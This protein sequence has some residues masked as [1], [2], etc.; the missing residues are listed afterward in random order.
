ME[1]T[2]AERTR[3]DR[4]H[5]TPSH[6]LTKTHTQ[7]RRQGE[8]SRKMRHTSLKY[9]RVHTRANT[10]DRRVATLSKRMQL[11][12]NSEHLAN[13]GHDPPRWYPRLDMQAKREPLL[14]SN[15]IVD[16]AATKKCND[17]VGEVNCTAADASLD[18]TAA[19]KPNAAFS[20]MM[21][22]VTSARRSAT[23]ARS[24]SAIF[25]KMRV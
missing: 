10:T 8:L 12:E 9:E 15:R 18:V 11:T 2:N 6:T 17:A 22:R 19:Y 25:G 14:E 7:T 4:T 20:L 16:Q 24:A 13:A 5:T 21:F 23:V 3:I 1:H